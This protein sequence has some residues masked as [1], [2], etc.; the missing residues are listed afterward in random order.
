MQTLCYRIDPVAVASDATSL[1]AT[2]A[3]FLDFWAAWPHPVRLISR[4]MPQRYQGREAQL[5]AQLAPLDRARAAGTAHRDAWRWRHLL[6]ERQRY[7]APAATQPLMCEHYLVTW[8]PTDVLAPTVQTRIERAFMTTATPTT[9]P[10]FWQHQPVERLRHLAPRVPGDPYLAVLMA[11]AVRGRWDLHT[12]HA[13]LGLDLPLVLAIDIQTP[14]KAGFHGT[15]RKVSEAEDA[16][17]YLAEK[18]P[19]DRHARL[20]RGDAE[21]ANDALA[22]EFIHPVGYV[23]LAIAET[24]R[25][26][27]QAVQ[28]VEAA[29]GTHLQLTRSPGV[30]AAQLHFFTTAPRV[31]IRAPLPTNPAPSHGVA[32]KTPFAVVR[33]ARATSTCWGTDQQTALL[34]HYDLGLD[35]KQNGSL[36]CLGRPMYGKTTFMLAQSLR[37]ATEGYQIVLMEP[38]SRGRLL[39]DA[40]G[41]ERS[42]RYTDLHATP[43]I[44]ILDPIAAPAG[45]QGDDQPPAARA[46][47]DF[48]VRNLEIALGNTS[49]GNTVAVRP[50]TNSERGL[51]DLAIRTDAVYGAQCYKL[52]TMTSATAPRLRAL[53]AALLDL[54][55]AGRADA[56]ALADEIDTNLLGTAAR[57]YDAPTTLPHSFDRDVTL[58]SFNNADAGMLPLLYNYVFSQL[59]R[60]IRRP[61]RTRPL[62]V[63]I[64][65]VWYMLAIGSLAEWLAQGVKTYRNFYAALWLF[66]QN[67][68]TFL[69]KDAEWGRFVTDTTAIRLFF[70]CDGEGTKLIQDAY[71]GRLLPAHIQRIQTLA[72][73]EYVGVFE[74]EIV[75]L[76]YTLNALEARVL[77][78]H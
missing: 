42:C 10:T 28:Q 18:N 37:L 21:L 70:R 8:A 5:G 29:V 78:K 48:I 45:D 41:D 22:R 68:D 66:D 61:G 40:I 6:A 74:E 20:A 60:Y 27:D 57:I 52:D 3:R 9:L 33:Q 76:D 50:F 16:L 47:R 19:R 1:D 13:L 39:R 34:H 55:R 7:T 35:R 56:L 14:P 26:L 44:N 30:Q 73:G 58:Y 15:A 32:H 36:L 62:V 4:L 43:S 25:L 75:T 53:V 46:Q 49:G 77:T 54:G 71:R 17:D 11:H 69:G 67:I 72:Q 51:I 59:N 12:W 65:E 2:A 31:A 24:E 64:D 63:P 23:V 38:A